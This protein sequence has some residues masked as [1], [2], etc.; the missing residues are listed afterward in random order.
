MTEIIE[1]NKIPKIKD[2]LKFLSLNCLLLP[3]KIASIKDPLTRSRCLAEIINEEENSEDG[4][5]DVICLQEVFYTECKNIITNTIKKNFP[6]IIQKAGYDKF[7]LG[8]DSG[9]YFA[10]KFPIVEHSFEKYPELIGADYFSCKGAQTCVLDLSE[11][12]KKPYKII[13][14]QSHL[15]SNPEGDILWKMFYAKT[16]EIKKKRTIDIRLNQSKILRENTEK[17]YEKYSKESF[18]SAMICGDFNVIAEMP[19]YCVE[20]EKEVGSVIEEVESLIVEKTDQNSLL[21]PSQEYLNQIVSLGEPVDILRSLYPDINKH[22]KPTGSTNVGNK[23]IPRRID[24]VFVYKKF[25][26]K[27]S[28]KL[29]FLEPLYIKQ[30]VVRRK[31]DLTFDVLPF[32]II[33]LILLLNIF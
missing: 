7:Y 17:M 24:Y 19:K 28:E 32:N 1:Q 23:S 33:Y 6:H 25:L 8:V 20:I 16:N 9:L 14:S 3:P 26:E 12:T 2:K 13:V 22:P 30:K 18:C 15:Q 27:N 11:L 10:S 5:Y 21:L 29:V 31:E 4:G